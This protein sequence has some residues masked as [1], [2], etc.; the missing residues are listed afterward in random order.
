MNLWT[1]IRIGIYKKL[2]LEL[3]GVIL[4]NFKPF[5]PELIHLSTLFFLGQLWTGTHYQIILQSRRPSLHLKRGSNMTK[6]HFSALCP[7]FILN[8]ESC[9][10][11]RIEIEMIRS[12]PSLTSLFDKFYL[13]SMIR[14][15]P[16]GIYYYA[17]RSVSDHGLHSK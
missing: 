9:G 12:G 6:Y 4:L 16:A 15:R 2:K 3:V 8:C 10:S 13:Q 7:A 11:I 1:L 17:C 5:Q 14:Y